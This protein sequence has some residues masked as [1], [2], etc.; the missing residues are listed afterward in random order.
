MERTTQNTGGSCSIYDV[1]GRS[2]LFCVTLFPCYLSSPLCPFLP[3]PVKHPNEGPLIN[4]GGIELS[5]LYYGLQGVQGERCVLGWKQT[6]GE[7]PGGAALKAQP[8]AVAVRQFASDEKGGQGARL[9]PSWAA[10][11][12]SKTG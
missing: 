7:Q 10:N 8:Q 1:E 5:S 4:L 11:S 3:S 12:G 2:F 6:N 9:A